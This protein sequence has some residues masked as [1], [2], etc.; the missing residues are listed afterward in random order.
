VTTGGSCGASKGSGGS[1]A[2]SSL[3]KQSST[4]PEGPNFFNFGEARVQE[5]L[6]SLPERS[7]NSFSSTSNHNLHTS[8]S[9]SGSSVSSI[10]VTSTRQGVVS[11]L[12]T[13][14]KGG[15]GPPPLTP[16][17]AF[18]FRPTTAGSGELN[19]AQR[20]NRTTPPT[21][22][23]ISSA[24]SAPINRSKPPTIE[25]DDS[26]PSIIV[27]RSVAPTGASYLPVFNFE[28]IMT[29]SRKRRIDEGSGSNND[30]VRM[31]SCAYVHHGEQ[32][33]ISPLNNHSHQQNHNQHHQSSSILKLDQDSLNNNN[34]LPVDLSRWRHHM[35]QSTPQGIVEL[36]ESTLNLKTSSN[37]QHHSNY[38]DIGNVNINNNR[39][40]VHNS[41][42]S[43][44]NN[45]NNYDTSTL[46]EGSG[47]K[48]NKRR[49]MKNL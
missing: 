18:N 9:F 49:R 15:G 19:P 10:S 28:P 42:F 23:A 25:L 44:S 43:C 8:T 17:S 31:K 21:L 35:P 47:S 1:L 2:S 5:Y 7:S 40:D 48:C 4:D 26:T 11:H 22:M 27:T 39:M 41:N 16:V 34:N 29:R 20:R 46:L 36:I 6:S 45:N 33:S 38:N 37:Y 30:N 32:I 3:S 14:S 12:K 13:A 24:T